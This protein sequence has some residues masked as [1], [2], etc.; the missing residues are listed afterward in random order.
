MFVSSK[1][2]FN[3]IYQDF[4]RKKI[5]TNERSTTSPQHAKCRYYSGRQP[6]SEPGLA[7]PF[8]RSPLWT[9]KKIKKRERGR[10]EGRRGREDRKKDRREE[11]RE[12]RREEKRREKR[13]EEKR[14][15]TRRT[16]GE[17]KRR[18]T[19]GERRRGEKKRRR[20]NRG[21]RER[22]KKEKK[23][24]KREREKEREN[25]KE[26]RKE[27]IK[28]GLA[29][30]QPDLFLSLGFVPSCSQQESMDEHWLLLPY[31]SY[32]SILCEICSHS[33]DE[34]WLS[35]L[36]V[37]HRLWVFRYDCWWRDLAHSGR[38]SWKKPEIP[39]LDINFFFCSRCRVYHRLW[40]DTAW[41]NVLLYTFCSSEDWESGNPRCDET[42]PRRRWHFDHQQQWMLVT[43]ATNTAAR[44]IQEWGCY[45]TWS[46]LPVSTVTRKQFQKTCLLMRYFLVIFVVLLYFVLFIVVCRYLSLFSGYY[47]LPVAPRT[48]KTHRLWSLFIVI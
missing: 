43:L 33:A 9:G 8:K 19:R 7:H 39:T 35:Q 13:R 26:R 37:R 47:P 22:E 44:M 20:E 46:L 21:E 14:R 40:R 24:R 5:V 36:W 17:E 27:R 32:V 6:L 29:R 34:F 45:W 1:R 42:E 15:R 12:K 31:A 18:R 23:E 25:E 41:R 3:E 16:R 30:F 10:G 2:I 11:R 4:W 28:A 48:I 38:V